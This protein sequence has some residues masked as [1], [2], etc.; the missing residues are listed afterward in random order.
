MVWVSYRGAVFHLAFPSNV[1]IRFY[2]PDKRKMV[3]LA[4]CIDKPKA[5]PPKRV[6]ISFGLLSL[7]YYEKKRP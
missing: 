6:V 7:L 5:P 1:P 2:A 3:E 4:K